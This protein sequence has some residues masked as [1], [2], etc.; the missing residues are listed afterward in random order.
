[1]TSTS[2]E[3]GTSCS[4]FV[5]EAEQYSSSC[6]VA[7]QMILGI[8]CRKFVLEDGQYSN[9]WRV[10]RQMI[11]GTSCSKFVLEDEQYSNSR[12]VATAGETPHSLI[13]WV[14]SSKVNRWGHSNV[15][16]KQTWRWC[17]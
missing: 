6:R 8:S 10:E 4:K 9:S 7:R 15:T 13:W 5:L 11:L 14:V 16:F 2:N 1:M 12:R 3:L 17:Q